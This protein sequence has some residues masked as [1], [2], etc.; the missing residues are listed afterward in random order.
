[1]TEE[2]QEKSAGKKA[3]FLFPAILIVLS[4]LVIGGALVYMQS[5]NLVKGIVEKVATKTLGVDVRIAALDISLK[6]KTVDVGGITVANPSGFTKPHAITVNR[7]SITLEDLAQGLI[8]FENILVDG[9]TVNLEVAESG[10]NLTT[11]RNNMDRKASTKTA[12]V[13][14]EGGEQPPMKVIIDNLLISK[15]SLNPTVTLAGGDLASVNLPNIQLQ[16]V[17]RKQNGVLASEALGQILD[18]VT[19]VSVNA[20]GKAGFLQ[21]MST[22]SLKDMQGSL[23]LSGGFVDKAKDDI[24]NLGENIKGLFGN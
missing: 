20:A 7:V 6:E 23:G 10:T 11:I 1:M 4:V 8:T 22:E 13:K 17:G 3:G 18:H 21:G 24:K 2:K 19:R 9:T 12:T 15:A 5:D 14:T 16:D